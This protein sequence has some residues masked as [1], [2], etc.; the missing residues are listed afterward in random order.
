ARP[1]PIYTLARQLETSTRP[2]PARCLWESSIA[3]DL[4]RACDCFVPSQSN[5]IRICNDL[6][7]MPPTLVL[8]GIV[9]GTSFEL[10]IGINGGGGTNDACKTAEPPRRARCGAVDWSHH[11]RSYAHSV[12]HRTGRSA[13]R[14]RIATLGLR[15]A[16][17]AG[18][19]QAGSGK[20][21]SNAAGHGAGSRSLHSSDRR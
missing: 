16:A 9:G 5:S 2:S 8:T 10:A 17:Q 20:T 21:R 6:P 19:R 3:S 15:G 14:E 11:D 4:G 18:G 7:N 12:C 13:R 1:I